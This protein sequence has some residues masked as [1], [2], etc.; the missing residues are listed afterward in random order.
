MQTGAAAHDSPSPKRPS[1][2][3]QCDGRPRS[4]IQG[5]EITLHAQDFDPPWFVRYV[6]QPTSRLFPNSPKLSSAFPDLTATRNF[7]SVLN[8]LG[9]LPFLLCLKYGDA[10]RPSAL[11]RSP[12]KCV[13]CFYFLL[14]WIEGSRG[15]VC[16]FVTFYCHFLKVLAFLKC[17]SSPL[18][19]QL[20]SR[21]L[22]TSTLLAPVSSLSFPPHLHKLPLWPPPGTNVYLF[23]GLI[24]SISYSIYLLGF[25]WGTLNL[26]RIDN[27]LIALFPK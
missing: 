9:P 10:Q 23:K 20:S 5:T 26:T 19:L 16:V 15:R 24:S 21:V 13:L 7:T 22:I 8:S 2:V 3:I 1:D 27:I 4:E 6:I 14:P 25:L 11:P 17:F 18:P 12:F